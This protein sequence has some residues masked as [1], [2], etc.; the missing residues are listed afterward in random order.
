MKKTNEVLVVGNL[1]ADP[2]EKAAEKNGPVVRFSVAQNIRR[3]NEQTKSYE[4]VRTNWFPVVCFGSLAAKA[5]AGL[6]KGDLVSLSGALRSDNY[7]DRNGEKRTSIQIVAYDIHRVE[8]L[9]SNAPN[10][11]G[12]MFDEANGESIPF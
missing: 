9:K 2:E 8:L 1:G 7:E 10:D 3:F 12:E 5:K 6:K 4:N 11:S